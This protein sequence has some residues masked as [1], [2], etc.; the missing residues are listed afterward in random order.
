MIFIE[1]SAKVISLGYIYTINNLNHVDGVRLLLMFTFLR[2]H[3]DEEAG[4]C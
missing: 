2:G 4:F 3:P 1:P